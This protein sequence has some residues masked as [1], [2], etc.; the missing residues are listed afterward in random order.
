MD[1]ITLGIGE[2]L[3]LS[4]VVRNTCGELR[5]VTLR[6]DD[7]THASRVVLPDNCPDAPN[8]DQIDTDGDGM[9]DACDLCSGI[10]SPD[11]RD[12][13]ADG[14]GDACDVCPA[15]PDPDQRD[16]DQ[17]GIG[18]ACDNCGALPSLDQRDGDGDGLG[19][20]CDQCPAAPGI[21]NGCPCVEQS[22]D[23][24]DACTAD[25]CS[26]TAGCQHA[27]ATSFD[28]VLCRLALLR[29]TLSGASASD[30]TP[31]LARPKSGLMRVLGRATRLSTGAAAD[32]GIRKLRRAE[33][34]IILLQRALE[35][36][37][38]RVDKARARSQLS[39]AL[40]TMLDG[41]AGDALGKATRLP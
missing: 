17:D 5:G 39:P 15:I 29:A 40:Q 12:T 38:K 16:L 10:S 28:A 3:S 27:P 13:D 34:R 25:T 41:L 7:L 22:C 18:D 6:F 31:Q 9:G 19:D 36:F 37:T 20:R 30:L 33:K 23:D 11:Q 21:E 4:I 26:P 35:Q 1:P 8:P 14:V 24:G 32:L 2:R